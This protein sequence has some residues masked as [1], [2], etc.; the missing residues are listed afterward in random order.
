MKTTEIVWP[1]VSDSE[2]ISTVTRPRLPRLTLPTFKGDVTHWTSFWDSYNSAIH[3]N[4]QLTTI[5]K[6]NYLHSLVKGPAAR[7]IKGLT[8]TEG[9]Y[10]SAFDLLKQ[11]Y[12]K[13]QQIIAAHMDELL[14]IP[15]CT[16]D[17]PQILRL[18]YDQLNVHIRGLA[19]LSVN[20]EQYGSLLIPI[21]TSKLP[22]DVQLRIAR[23]MEDEVWK[24]GDLLGIIKLKQERLV[25]GQSSNH[26]LDQIPHQILTTQQLVHLSPMVLAYSVSIVKAALFSLM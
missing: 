1:V 7:S 10:K 21:I 6:F 22:G 24:I 18:V 15:N 2:I 3:S 9:N 26:I 13:P 20:P 25:K 23:E 19:A 14:K 5:D 16:T 8:L 11:R 17:K 12:G 4:S